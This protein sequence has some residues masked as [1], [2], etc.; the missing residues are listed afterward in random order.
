MSDPNDAKVT[1]DRGFKALFEAF[2]PDAVAFFA[3]ELIALHG[4]PVSVTLAQQEVFSHVLT[5]TSTSF[6]AG[7]ITTWTDGSTTVIL[8][9]EHHSEARKIRKR[10]L[11]HYFTGLALLHEDADSYPVVFITDRGERAAEDHWLMTIAG[12]EVFKLAWKVVRIS[13]TDLPHLRAAQ[14]KIAA[15]LI[16]LTIDE[17]PEAGLATVKAMQAVGYTLHEI[18]RFLSLV[19]TLA[20]I[21]PEDHQ[22]FQQLLLA[23]V[24]AMRTFIDDIAAENL[25][26]GELTAILHLLAKRKITVADAREEIAELVAAGTVTSEQAKEA[27]AKIG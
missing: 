4:L 10:S 9:I 19:T 1:Q 5:D 26:K 15:M 25:A 23:E 11:A 3:P 20:R 16:A 18:A 14:N 2:G 21:S 13:K 22:R 17:A 12:R 7:L 6:D 8:L 27:I 24:P